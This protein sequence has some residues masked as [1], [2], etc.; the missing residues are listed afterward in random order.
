MNDYYKY[1]F[2]NE[3]LNAIG[4]Q[5][6]KEFKFREIT[7]TSTNLWFKLKARSAH[8]IKVSECILAFYI[9]FANFFNLDNWLRLQCNSKYLT[10][11]SLRT[12]M[13]TYYVSFKF[14]VN[15]STDLFWSH[16]SVILYRP[17]S[18]LSF[19]PFKI[20]LRIFGAN[21]Q[22]NV[23]LFRIGM[24]IWWWQKVNN[25]KWNYKIYFLRFKVCKLA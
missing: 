6:F 18:S 23:N 14:T 21:K 12:Y 17:H 11:Y 22:K 3:F 1:F 2:Q 4:W 19:V 10:N 7:F 20:D 9:R 24:R 15:M 16:W 13:Y 25:D 5:F 8:L